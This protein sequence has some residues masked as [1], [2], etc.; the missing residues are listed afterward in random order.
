MLSGL[1]ATDIVTFCKNGITP[2]S[3]Y[4]RGVSMHDWAAEEERTGGR[5]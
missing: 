1:R 4:A 2:M 5:T 3:G